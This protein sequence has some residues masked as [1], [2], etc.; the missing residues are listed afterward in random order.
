MSTREVAILKVLFPPD[1]A[2]P[3]DRID[4]LSAIRAHIAALTDLAA[5]KPIPPEPTKRVT[6]TEISEVATLQIVELRN[7]PDN[8]GRRRTWAEV[9]TELN[10]GLSAEAVRHRYKK[11]KARE[12]RKGQFTEV[13]EAVA[14]GATQEE[15][16]TQPPKPAGGAQERQNHDLSPIDAA[17]LGMADRGA[18]NH[19]ICIA[20][21][22][23]FARNFSTGQIAEKIRKLSGGRA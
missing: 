19:E 10:L 9:A 12:K 18:L 20:I 4:D 22:R 14:V 2:V 7:Q 3:A 5:P 16:A 21:S 11:W 15:R 1:G 17:I 8:Q 13:I 23:K 6:K